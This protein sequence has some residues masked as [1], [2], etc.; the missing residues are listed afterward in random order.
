MRDLFKYISTHLQHVVALF[1]KILVALDFSTHSLHIID[2]IHEIPGVREVILLH[3]VDSSNPSLVGWIHGPDIENAKIILA[4][5]KNVLEEAGLTVRVNVKVLAYE[6]ADATIPGVILKT[7][8]SHGVSLIVVATR[9][10]NPVKE[11]L[12]GSVSSKILRH[13]KT[14]VLVMHDPPE[15]DDSDHGRFQPHRELFSRVLVPMDFSS[16]SSEV[17][18]LVKAL[19]GIRE[20]ILLNVVSRADSL[21]TIKGAV[22]D[23]Q[24]RL[25]AMKKEFGEG[26]VVKSHVRV[27]DPT[28]MILAV[29]HDDDVSLVAMSAFGTDRMGATILG[30]TT[31]TVVRGTKRP[32]LVLRTGSEKKRT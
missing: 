12:L 2:E 31:F 18:S 8:K 29:A 1:E 21:T 16:F 24:L 28:D 15:S 26:I 11:L 27:G 3:V 9:G 32:V 19:P 6:V 30:S 17:F 23:A 7:A 10:M 13:A 22:A 4:E 20:I 25:D 14:S 5:K